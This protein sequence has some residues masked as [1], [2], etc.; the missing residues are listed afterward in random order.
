MMD[1]A[2]SLPYSFGAAHASPK[3]TDGGIFWPLPGVSSYG[4]FWQFVKIHRCLFKGSSKTYVAITDQT[5]SN[6]LKMVLKWPR[7][8]VMLRRSVV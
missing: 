2:I 5:L 1:L 3:L 6:C 4:T 7:P 8:W